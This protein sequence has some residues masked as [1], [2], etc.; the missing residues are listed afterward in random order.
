MKEVQIYKVYPAIP[1]PL[2][3]LDYLARNLW[4]CWNPEAIELFHRIHP[5]QWEKI[6]KN[7]VA[8]LSHISQRRFDDLSKDE[9]FLGHLGRVKAKFERMFSYVSQIKEF[10][11]D[12]KETIAYFSMEFGL[13]ESLPLFAGGLGVLAGDHLKA[14]STLGIPLTGIGLLFREGYFK[15]FL[16][17]NGWQQ[18]T[19]PFNDMFDLPVQ[20]VKDSSGFEIK[21]EIPGPEGLITACVWQLKVGKIRLFLLDT[22]LPENPVIIRDITSRLYAS[23]GE[24]RVAQEILLGIGGIKILSAMDMFPN[25]SH[26]NEGHCAFAG[27]ERICII[28]DKYD[29]DFESAF[30]IC[31]RSCVFT[32]HTPVAAGHDEFPKE[33]ILPYIQPYADKFAISNDELLSWGEPHGMKD[34]GKFSMFIF[35]AKLSGYINGVSRLHGQVARTMWQPLWPRR[36]VEEIPIS[37]IT[38][39]VHICS[40][41]SRHKNALFERYLSS[42]W[43]NRQGNPNLISRIDNIEDADLW[44]V[45]ELDRSNLIK[46]CRDTLLAQYERR[47]APRT[48]LDEVVSVLDHRVL[49]ICFARR[50]ATYK[51]AGLLLK[52]IPR[53]TRLITDEDRPIQLVFA[54]KAHPNDNEG[55]DIIKQIVEFARLHNVRHRVVFLENYDINIA[56]YMVQGCDVWLN[57]PRRPNEACGTSGMKAA[58]NGGLNLSI[59][60]G[61]WCEG[62]RESRGWSIGN[63]DAYEDHEYQ[64]E[65]ESQALYNILENDVIPTFYERKRG[66]PPEKWI[67]MMKEAMKMAIID[68][69][70]DRM[71]REYSERFYIPASRNFKLLTQDSAW[72]AKELAL[73]QSRLISLWSGIRVSTPKL[74]TEADFIVRDTFRITLEVFLG[75]LTPEEVEVQVYHGKVKSSDHLEGSMAET[76]W[77]QETISEGAHIYACTITCSDS[78]RFGYTARVIPK[79]DEVLNSHTPGLITWVH[80]ED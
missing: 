76:M 3:F 41:L 18:E 58:A 44:H 28:M 39:G 29:V 38:N 16:D 26:M 36:H 63:G 77:L 64:D 46:K 9:S 2:S 62:F 17:H 32:T 13:H 11:L 78:G 10:D 61:W 72:K 57:T 7:P 74:T 6:G 56:R 70:S 68:F 24:V 49:T 65:V 20:K 73:T 37:H 54:G 23:H 27:L 35:G 66:N 50:F 45:H 59:L 51:R 14:S 52:D 34:T 12:P 30:Q 75:E 47:N 67:K 80:G 48:V 53:L 71:V 4:W 25:I 69:S 1:E 43:S 19:Y 15:Q 60:D 21:I 22:D 55:K 42:D 79:G 40:Y 8:F 33:L 31:K 5:A